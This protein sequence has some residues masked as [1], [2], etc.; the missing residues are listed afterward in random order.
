MMMM[1]ELMQKNRQQVVSRI[2]KLTKILVALVSSVKDIPHQLLTTQLV[3]DYSISSVIIDEH[4]ASEIARFANLL[5]QYFPRLVKKDDQNY[6]AYSMPFLNFYNWACNTLGFPG[7][8]KKVIPEPSLGKLWAIPLDKY[9]LHET[10]FN[11]S[12]G[13]LAIQG[14]TSLAAAHKDLS[15]LFYS[16]FDKLVIEKACGKNQFAFRYNLINGLI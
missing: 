14:V 16:I 6:T 2:K 4:E 1:L 5:R 15:K 8:A 13:P 9:T 3:Q 7:R 10:F 11:R 12:Q